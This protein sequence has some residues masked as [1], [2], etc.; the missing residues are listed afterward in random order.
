MRISKRVKKYTTIGQSDSTW[1]L[2]L[3]ICECCDLIDC[4]TFLSNVQYQWDARLMA[5]Q[6]REN[7]PFDRNF[8]IFVDVILSIDETSH[9]NLF[10]FPQITIYNYYSIKSFHIFALYYA[11]S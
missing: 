7:T 4:F 8:S 11:L 5:G 10:D 2:F 6:L 3:A 1:Q 9:M